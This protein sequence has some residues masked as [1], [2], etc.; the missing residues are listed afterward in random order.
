[1]LS[2]ALMSSSFRVSGSKLIIIGLVPYLKTKESS[3][4]IKDAVCEVCDA[5]V[6]ITYDETENGAPDIPKEKIE[7]DP[8]AAL[9][10]HSDE[11]PNINIKGDF[12]NG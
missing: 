2:M 6:D 1:M 10:A 11:L 5:V 8:L 7:N 4:M 9:A 12:N 3:R